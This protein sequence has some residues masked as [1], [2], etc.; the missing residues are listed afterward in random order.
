MSA[1]KSGTSVPFLFKHIVAC[2]T[3]LLFVSSSFAHYFQQYNAPYQKKAWNPDELF[4]LHIDHSHTLNNS[5]SNVIVVIDASNITFN[6]NGNM[7][8]NIGFTGESGILIKNKTNVTI[9]AAESHIYQFYNGIK[10]EGGS[11]HTINDVIIHD[12]TYG[13]NTSSSSGN[14][15]NN[16][17][18]HEAILD[19]IKLVSANNTTI[20]NADCR[21]SQRYGIY[22]NNCYQM[23]ITDSKFHD[24]GEN[25]LYFVNVDDAYMYYT[26]AWRDLSE[27]TVGNGFYLRS[28]STNS[29]WMQC[30]AT[31]NPEDG[32]KISSTCTG[33]QWWWCNGSGNGDQDLEDPNY[34]TL[35]QYYGCD[36][37]N[38]N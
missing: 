38:I 20:V 25:C 34:Q 22:G 23:T 5:Y 36:F 12:P 32:F 35:N 24:S 29:R 6:M 14:T 15:Y 33:G 18:T 21:Y 30:N 13:I 26:D 8:S 16:I 37:V 31:N 19:G 3:L 28:G 27:I 10:I 4:V 17:T 11:G 9:N 2:A 7:L 1:V